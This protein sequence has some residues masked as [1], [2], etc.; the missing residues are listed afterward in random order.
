M[1]KIT[2]KGNTVTITPQD[3]RRVIPRCLYDCVTKT[4]V[5]DDLARLI[6][7]I[8][9]LMHATKGDIGKI[10]RSSVNK[11]IVDVKTDTGKILV[12]FVE[13]EK[14]AKGPVSEWGITYTFWLSGLQTLLAQKA[15]EI[16]I[17]RHE[18]FPFTRLEDNHTF[19][20][21]R[22][23]DDLYRYKII[24]NLLSPDEVEPKKPV[25]IRRIAGRIFWTQKIV[26][27][28]ESAECV[29]EIL[30]NGNGKD[31][32]RKIL[33]E[34]RGRYDNARLHV[35]KDVKRVFNAKSAICYL[36]ETSFANAFMAS[37]VYSDRERY[38]LRTSE[39]GQ[40]PQLQGAIR[41]PKVEIN[42]KAKSGGTQVLVFDNGFGMTPGEL[43]ALFTSNQVVKLTNG[44]YFD[45]ASFY[46]THG[47]TLTL[48]PIIADITGAKISVMSEPGFTIFEFMVPDLG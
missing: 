31:L 27:M 20:T 2:V 6:P 15:R 46:T 39:Y 16:R 41:E 48:F 9:G 23:K 24:Y 17:G 45:C 26:S 28:K 3:R 47:K 30:D 7:K 35:N 10:T 14:T 33:R 43:S 25:D 13:A 18:K 32:P 5:Q 21:A 38:L 37:F 34:I 36:L 44:K 12:K 19:V 11:H 1:S 40:L 8:E 29:K 42:I 22:M 4:G